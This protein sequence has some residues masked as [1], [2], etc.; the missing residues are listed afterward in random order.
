M[1]ATLRPL[2]TQ[3]TIGEQTMAEERAKA[4][5]LEYANR[6][7]REGRIAEKAAQRDLAVAKWREAAAAA[8][9]A[10]HSAASAD[11]ALARVHATVEAEEVA[12]RRQLLPPHYVNAARTVLKSERERFEG[13][14]PLSTPTNQASATVKDWTRTAEQVAWVEAAGM[15]ANALQDLEHFELGLIEPPTDLAEWLD[16]VCERAES[17]VLAFGVPS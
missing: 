2:A 6:R 1:P 9:L 10:K 15:I 14:A 11:M 13:G 12:L 4:A 17:R 16:H 3:G 7:P 5:R 8:E